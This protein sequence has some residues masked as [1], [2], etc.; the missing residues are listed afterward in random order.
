MVSLA[1]ARQGYHLLCPVYQVSISPP[2]LHTHWV[3]YMKLEVISGLTRFAYKML[4][5]S[6]TSQPFLAEPAG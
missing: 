3:I 1:A 5:N 4:I 2:T 6:G